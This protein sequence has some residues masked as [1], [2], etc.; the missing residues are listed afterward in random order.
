MTSILDKIRKL[1]TKAEG[2]DNEHEADIFMSKAQELMLKHSI[3]EAVARQHN[4]NR[5]TLIEKRKIDFGRMLGR[6]DKVSMLGSIAKHHQC[7]I[8][9]S[10]GSGGYVVIC[11]FPE[12]IDSV[13]ALWTSLCL[14]ADVACA[15]AMAE[16]Q[17]EEQNVKC[18]ERYLENMK[19]NGWRIDS[20]IH[21]GSRQRWDGLEEELW[22]CKLS[23]KVNGR[24]FKVSFL[25][26]FASKIAERLSES[27]RKAMEGAGATAGSTALVVLKTKADEVD[28]F[29]SENVKL[30]SGGYSRRSF[31]RGAYSSGQKAGT[32]A[33]MG[34]SLAAGNRSLNR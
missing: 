10:T 29:V 19:R 23:R 22:S 6:N 14:Q 12:D 30:S 24:T 34:G 15:K 33:T 31:S 18:D 16:G 3:D 32:S 1:L 13:E 17:R 4:P 8:W 28:A 11:G 21:D 27:A 20:Q 25:M 9:H 7:R 2:T 26:G 5:K